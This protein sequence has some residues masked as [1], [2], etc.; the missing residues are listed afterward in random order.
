MKH[1]R[2]RFILLTVIFL[3]TLIFPIINQFTNI[4]PDI[5]NSENK[6][7]TKKPTLIIKEIDQ[8]PLQFE[9]FFNDHFS[10]RQRLVKK[11]VDFHLFLFQMT[12]NPDQVVL[13][14]DK[15][16]FLGG[17]ETDVYTGKNRLTQEELI[18][19]TEE[20]EYRQNYLQNL[21]CQFYF[22]IAPVKSS[23]YPEFFPKKYLISNPESGGRQLISYLNKNS[24]VKTIDL[25]KLNQWKNL[26]LLYYKIDN[27]WNKQGAFLASNIIIQSLKK[28]FPNLQEWPLETMTINK[29]VINTG[30]LAGMLSNTTLFTDT[31]YELTPEKGFKAKEVSKREYPVVKGFPY[32][33]EFESDREIEGSEFPKILIISDSF[34]GNLFPYISESFSRSV[35]IFDSWQYKLNENIVTAEKP[36]I[37]ILMVLESN[38]RNMFEHFSKPNNQTPSKK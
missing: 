36:D 10:I 23:I 38:L 16:L 30:N 26:G 18:L 22:V 8:Y 24:S 25:Y 6:E 31:L 35:K 11:Y 12:P 34:G 7:P 15:W 4:I 1:L 27:H 14:K 29:K 21:N 33:W 2:F 9:N 20:L 13:G 28:D 3:L 19:L 37:V 32:P 17:K 5:A